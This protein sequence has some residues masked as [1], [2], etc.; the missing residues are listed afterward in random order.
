MKVQQ[1]HDPLDMFWGYY[2]KLKTEHKKFDDIPDEK[3]LRLSRMFKIMRYFLQKKLE[4]DEL[5]NQ[6]FLYEMQKHKTYRKKAN[7]DKNVQT[8][9]DFKDVKKTDS[10]S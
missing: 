10:P 5:E 1:Q 3:I 4:I 9:P 2:D 7:I 6:T 8:M